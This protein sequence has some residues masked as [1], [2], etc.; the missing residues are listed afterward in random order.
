MAIT[1]KRSQSEENLSTVK[2]RGMIVADGVAAPT[3]TVT[4]TAN[5]SSN[6]TAASLTEFRTT[7]VVQIA[8]AGSGAIAEWFVIGTIG[9]GGSPSTTNFSLRPSKPV[10]SAV[11][12]ALMEEYYRLRL[13]FFPEKLT[14]INRATGVKHEWMRGMPQNSAIRTEANGVVTVLSNS[15]I[16]VGGRGAFIHPSILPAN[17]VTLFD[18]DYPERT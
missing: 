5:Q 6:L 16:V 17:S 9:S 10:V 7:D 12:N 1:V 13:P 2:S 14:L 11:T 8:G 18:V 3:T 15:G 4:A